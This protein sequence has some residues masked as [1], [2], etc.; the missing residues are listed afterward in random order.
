MPPRA[1]FFFLL[2]ILTAAP[3]MAQ[4]PAGP[5]AR[6][7]DWNDPQAVRQAT[8]QEPVRL[9]PPSTEK[10]VP[11]PAPGK[12]H[13]GQG[14]GNPFASLGTLVVSLAVVLGLFFV[15]SWCVK[16][17]LPKAGMKLPGEVFEVL[18]QTRL[19]GR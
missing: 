9:S 4:G 8:R 1:R 18:G 2:L 16:R 3:A 6:H 14:A 12:A 5:A 19:G 11:L 13:A 15:A 17:S 10:S 7:D